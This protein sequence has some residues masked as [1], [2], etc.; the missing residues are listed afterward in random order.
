M[1][2]YLDIDAKLIE[3]QVTSAVAQHLR[4]GMI[5][6]SCRYEYQSFPSDLDGLV[7]GFL[8]NEKVI[9]FCESKH[10]MDSNYNKAK[11]QLCHTLKNWE[12][13][14]AATREDLDDDPNLRMDYDELQVETYRNYNPMFADGIEIT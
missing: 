4:D 6:K 11:T 3:K 2:N 12:K 7:A 9:A 8:G 14:T 13:L 10:N 5:I 1:K